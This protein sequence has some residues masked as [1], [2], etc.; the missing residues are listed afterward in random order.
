MPGPD[1]SSIVELLDILPDAVLVVDARGALRYA[2][3]AVRALLGHAP[4]DLVGQP[5]AVLLPPGAR[6]RHEGLVARFRVEGQ[7]AM[8]GSRPVLS[9]LHASGRVVPVSI[10]ICNLALAGHERVSVA[11][12]HDVSALKTP[13]DR[14]TA[15]AETDPLTG[16]GN[17]VRLSRRL[18][19][20]LAAERPFA[21]L[22]LAVRAPVDDATL[23]IVGQ[24]LVAQVRGCDTAVRLQ[25]GDFAVL[26][27]APA[28]RLRL[29]ERAQAIRAQLARPLRGAGMVAVQVG[30][31]ARP[32]DG[33]T[34]AELMAAA[35][36]A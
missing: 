14:A 11:I 13:L 35:A 25:G 26:V 18:Q 28:V 8:M 31:A 24:R 16:L 1:L 33:G 21:L 9:A 2:N 27:D 3:P 20:M 19:A 30:C 4:A 17:A 36:P 12:V 23:R 6:A 5:L 15:Q 10:S 7:A 32:E 34:E 29:H 22:R